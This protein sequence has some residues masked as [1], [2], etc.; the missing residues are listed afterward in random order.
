MAA[1]TRFYRYDVQYT[2]S[3]HYVCDIVLAPYLQI[4]IYSL[5]A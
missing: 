1:N 3:T 4:I 5:K 2:M